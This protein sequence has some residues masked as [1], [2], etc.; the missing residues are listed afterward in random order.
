MVLDANAAIA[1]LMWFV[2][3]KAG[4]GGRPSAMLQR[5]SMEGVARAVDEA[6]ESG[7]LAI[8]DTVANETV[9]NLENAFESAAQSADAQ[10]GAGAAAVQDALEEF[11]RLYVIFGI[12]D[13]DKYKKEI[14]RMFAEIWQDPRMAGPVGRWQRVKERHGKGGA[15]PSL[16]THGAD[17][18]I[19]STAADRAARGEDVRLVT[20]D[21]DLLAFADAI[22]ERF[23][24]EVVDGA[25]L[26]R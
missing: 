12:R 21:H 2:S 26:P 17:F 18:M 8:P 9:D 19:L 15:R 11:K 24:V 16:E 22:R 14:D 1:H 6:A 13:E 25:S 20:F 4:R 3:K 10:P 5:R 7:D 23:G